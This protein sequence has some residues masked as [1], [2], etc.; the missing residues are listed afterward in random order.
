M[1][2]IIISLLTLLLVSFSASA[3]DDEGRLWSFGLN[4]EIGVS[5]LTG[6]GDKIGLG[7]QIGIIADCHINSN[8]FAESGICFTCIS[9]REEGVRGALSGIYGKI[10]LLIGMQSNISSKNKLTVQVGPA[11]AYGM[12]GNNLEYQ[13][14]KYDYFQMVDRLDVGIEGKVGIVANDIRWTIGAYYG[15]ISPVEY[16]NYHNLTVFLG[17]TKYF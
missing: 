11:L 3:V 5:N 1:K 6:P 2:T 7:S 16:L 15:M 13:G 4:A 17:A 12:V 8:I 14:R 10:P 9:H